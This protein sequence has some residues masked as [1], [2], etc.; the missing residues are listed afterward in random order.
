MPTVKKTPPA[1]SGR[2]TPGELIDALY[3]MREERLALGKRLDDMKRDEDSLRRHIVDLLKKN[4]L[5]G[6]R[7]KLA[8]ASIMRNTVVN[9][10]DWAAYAA[11]VFKKR[12][13][14]LLWQRANQSAVK[15]RLERGE[16]IPGI[17]LSDVEDLSLSKS[18]RGG[19]AAG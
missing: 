11:F 12:D 17:E 15:E 13:S 8:S 3:S 1:P 16:K 6:A 2:K 9:M 7:G 14:S 10:R 19:K 18:T 4:G 5:D